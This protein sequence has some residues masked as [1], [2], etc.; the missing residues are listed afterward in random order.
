MSI[1]IIHQLQKNLSKSR[2]G[3]VITHALQYSFS[4]CTLE[5][6]DLV[7]Y[8][9]SV[10]SHLSCVSSKQQRLLNSSAWVFCP[11]GEDLLDN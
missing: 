5:S 8:S 1:I 4:G 9:S 6:E 11:Q 10:L 2:W 3:V 7:Y